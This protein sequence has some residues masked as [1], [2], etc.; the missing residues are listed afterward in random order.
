MQKVK[1]GFVLD[2]TNTYPT[3]LPRA[4]LYYFLVRPLTAL[5]SGRI[6]DLLPTTLS[7]GVWDVVQSGVATA[8]LTTSVVMH[9][10][11]TGVQSYEN[12]VHVIIAIVC[13]PVKGFPIT[14]VSVSFDVVFPAAIT[15]E[16]IN[17]NIL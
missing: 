12:Y 17:T 10:Y 13:G 1:L 8:F 5:V 4:R 16:V 2:F 9:I 14:A 15:C 7:L 3:A 11:T 6:D